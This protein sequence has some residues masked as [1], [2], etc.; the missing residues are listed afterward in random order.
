M[1]NELTTTEQRDVDFYGDS[2][3][4][5]KASDGQIY[6]PIGQM[7]R[8]LGIDTQG[9]TQRIRR[10]KILS[11]GE[12]VCN[13]HTPK[14]GT[15]STTVLRVDLIPF[16]L[17]GIRT[18][19]LS[20]EIRPKLELLQKNA[21]RILWEAFQAGDLT[22]DDDLSDVAAIDPE[23]AEALAIAEAVVKMARSHVRL[24]RQV[25][26]NEGR[27]GSAETRLDAIEATLGNP[28][29][30]VSAEQAMNISQAV[31]VIALELGKRS[32]RSE[33]GNIFGELYRR[34]KV[35]S[36][37]EI[38]AGDYAEAMK[39]LSDWYSSLTGSELPF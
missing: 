27:I 7:C 4:A 21:A 28:D 11:D 3:T 30:F 9:Q 22:V 31:K 12:G 8:A 5:I 33:F 25:A 35:P 17:S 32:G 20:D 2:L 15:Q 37:R 29:R 26:A 19:A 23:A 16:W 34:F 36:Y 6:A 1:T 24:L 18:N 38:A 10:H 39:F 14:G 13:L